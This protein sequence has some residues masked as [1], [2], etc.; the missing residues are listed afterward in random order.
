MRRVAIGLALA[1]SLLSCGTARGERV[2]LL[3]TQLSVSGCYALATPLYLVAD[4]EYGTATKFD[5]GDASAQPLSWPTGYT[6][7]RVGSEVEVRDTS[8][9]VVAVTGRRYDVYVVNVGYGVEPPERIAMT[10]CIHESSL[11]N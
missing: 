1:V 2:E 9:N 10:G 8:D 6:G 7:W 3:I 5:L 11:G 4:P